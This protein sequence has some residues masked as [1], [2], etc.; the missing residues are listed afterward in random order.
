MQRKRQTH[1]QMA[2]H[3]GHHASMRMDGGETEQMLVQYQKSRGGGK[4]D[5]LNSP[6]S[7]DLKYNSVHK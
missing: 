3:Q 2:T 1:S 5:S 7:R 4:V 6:N